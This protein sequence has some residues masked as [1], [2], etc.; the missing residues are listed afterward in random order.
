M[1]PLEVLL[2]R[3]VPIKYPKFLTR[4]E[5]SKLN[6]YI[7]IHSIYG[8][9]KYIEEILRSDL[10]LDI[11]LFLVEHD[12]NHTPAD[13]KVSFIVVD[14]AISRHHNERW[15]K[16]KLLEIMDLVQNNPAGN[17]IC[18]EML[19]FTPDLTIPNTLRSHVRLNRNYLP[20]FQSLNKCIKDIMIQPCSRSIF[21]SVNKHV[22]LHVKIKN[23]ILQRFGMLGDTERKICIP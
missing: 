18:F 10:T 11:L 21:G 3:I 4:S 16:A 8:L 17:V 9:P 19:F 13:S 5:T 6:V 23:S 22:A 2:R 20:L 15:H 1:P 12:H 14:F 7:S